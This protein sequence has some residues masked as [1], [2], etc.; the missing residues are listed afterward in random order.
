MC[1]SPHRHPP[2]KLPSDDTMVIVLIIVMMKK[3]VMLVNSPD[4]LHPKCC[5]LFQF[6]D[7]DGTSGD[8]G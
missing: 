2:Q 4:R 5:P 1:A 7:V 6:G 8:D 3:L